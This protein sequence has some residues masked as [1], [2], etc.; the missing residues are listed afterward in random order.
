MSKEKD[1][2]IAQLSRDITNLFKKQ[3][4]ILEDIREDHREMMRNL[5]DSLPEHCLENLL[6]ADY[7]SDSR[8]SFYRKKVLDSG[9]EAIRG[10]EDQLDKLDVSIKDTD[11]VAVTFN[12]LMEFVEELRIKENEK[13]QS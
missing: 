10:M 8:F 4:T 7:F 13:T 9:N 2:F 5:Q 6:D 1:Y 12:Q 11:P 3:L